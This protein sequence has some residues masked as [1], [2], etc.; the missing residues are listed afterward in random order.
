[1]SR[2][3]SQLNVTPEALRLV[4]EGL[5]SEL[6][7]EKSKERYIGQFRIFL[8]DCTLFGCLPRLFPRW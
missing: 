8:R 3:Y 1:M 4:A 5:S 6:L 7:P 2:S